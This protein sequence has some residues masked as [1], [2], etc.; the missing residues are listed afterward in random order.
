MH[1]VNTLLYIL[2]FTLANALPISRRST[3]NQK[4][5]VSHF[6]VGNSYPYTVENWASDIALAKA[7]GIDAF[8]LNV[9]TDSWQPDRVA[10]A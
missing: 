9:G 8:A 7:S 10:D 5:V 1:A 4:Y 6:M 2:C 3:G